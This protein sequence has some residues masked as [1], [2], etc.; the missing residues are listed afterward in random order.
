VLSLGGESDLGGGGGSGGG[1]GG[2]V[3]GGGKIWTGDVSTTR[4]GVQ[5]INDAPGMISL[6]DGEFDED[7]N[8]VGTG[9]Q[10][11]PRHQLSF[12]NSIGIL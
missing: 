2:G 3:A 11:S 10:C 1:R 9:G 5:I 8:K 7:A 4:G 6:L 12:L